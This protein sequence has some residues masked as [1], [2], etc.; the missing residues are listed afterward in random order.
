MQKMLHIA[1]MTGVAGTENHLLTLLPGLRARGLDVHL[2]VLVEP[3]KPMDA[4][5]AHMTGLGV[6]AESMIIKRDVEF[7][8]IGRLAQKIRAGGYETVHTHLIHADWHGV[9]AARR[10]GVR[11]IFWSGHNDDPF[12]HRLPIRLIQAYLWRR[13]SAGIA[14]SEAVRQFMI[15]IEFAPPDKAVTVRYG[16]NV[17]GAADT[18]GTQARESFRAELGID[19]GAKVAGSV[20]RLIEQKGLPHAIQAFRQVIDNVPGA[21]YVIIGDGP[22]RPALEAQINALGLAGKVHL[23]GWRSNAAALMPAFDL[24]LMPSLWEGFGLVVLEAMAA[25]LPVI[26]SRISAL[27]EIVVEGETGYLV[28]PADSDGLAKHLTRLLTDPALATHLGEA[29]LTRLQNEFSADRMID[30]T[31]D[32]YRRYA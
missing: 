27:P 24:F 2:I 22:L 5:I 23:P 8:L 31:M 13:I 15:Q 9:V 30:Q 32:V 4:Y 7:P 18:Q 6:P 3:D 25:S 26:A 16:L 17:T 12:R 10:A 28:T 19:P 21:H 29:G 14:I 11:K 1:K 20:C